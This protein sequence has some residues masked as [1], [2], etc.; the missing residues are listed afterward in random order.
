MEE[1]L[2]RGVASDVHSSNSYTFY[3][4]VAPPPSPGLNTCRPHPSIHL[5]R[6]IRLRLLCKS[7]VFLDVCVCTH[8]VSLSFR[9]VHTQTNASQNPIQR[10]CVCVCVCVCVH[11]FDCIHICMH[12][13][14]YDQLFIY[15]EIRVLFY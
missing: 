8:R 6:A 5:L 1:K 4:S 15:L 13:F 12:L 3:A 9:E 14:L 2:T 7:P 11:K 10:V